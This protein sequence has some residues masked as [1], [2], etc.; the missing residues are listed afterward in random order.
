MAYV[1]A[2]QNRG[3]QHQGIAHFYDTPVLSLRNAAYRSVLQN[4]SLIPE[5]FFVH[6]N[7][8]IDTRHVSQMPQTTF[9]CQVSQELMADVMRC[10]LA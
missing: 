7:G 2:D 9:L 1:V 10:S 3:G 8:E 6:E 5:Y 4:E